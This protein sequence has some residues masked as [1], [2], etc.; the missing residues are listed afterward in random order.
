MA[1]IKAKKAPNL[2][3]VY[4]VAAIMVWFGGLLG[5]VYLTTFPTKAFADMREYQAAR[6]QT[7]SAQAPRP[8]D[9][10]YIRG[11]ILA[12]RS[13]ESKRE[14]LTAAGP[15]TVSLSAGEMNAW[16]NARLSTAAPALNAQDSDLVIVPGLPNFAIVQGDGFYINIPLSVFV[17]G[18]QHEIKLTAIGSVGK[19]GFK[20]A[21]VS[22]NA[23]A[24]PLPGILGGQVLR[25]FAQAF[26]STEDYE[27]VA[28]ALHRSESI[29]ME[30]DA[31]VFSLR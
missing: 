8:G 19:G 17:F 14:A 4:L 18:S 27:I 29:S 20:P 6:G 13:W 23:A 30:A 16:V 2:F 7:D 21:S 5:F 25:S 10:F 24:L 11:P 28:E 3:G 22:L 26:Q 15:Q 1:S 12:S 31:L 9:Q